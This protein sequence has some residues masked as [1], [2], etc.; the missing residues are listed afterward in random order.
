MYEYVAYAQPGFVTAGTSS[1]NVIEAICVDL[2]QKD[3]LTPDNFRVAT[4][5]GYTLHRA[6]G[7]SHL[8]FLN[9]FDRII[10]S[11]TTYQYCTN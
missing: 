6:V 4:L 11:Y 1:W 8:T 7:M 9:S 2:I 10:T 5:S 3:A